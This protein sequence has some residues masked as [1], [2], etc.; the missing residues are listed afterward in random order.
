M[1]SLSALQTGTPRHWTGTDEWVMKSACVASE[2]FLIKRPFS[3]GNAIKR[4]YTYGKTTQK[5]FHKKICCA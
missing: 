2:M 3:Q 4:R 1:S 5:E